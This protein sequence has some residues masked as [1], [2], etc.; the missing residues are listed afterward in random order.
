MFA[1]QDKFEA[2]IGTILLFFHYFTVYLYKEEKKNSIRV[3]TSTV[4][5]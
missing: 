3:E 4:G 1:L 2:N 5:I